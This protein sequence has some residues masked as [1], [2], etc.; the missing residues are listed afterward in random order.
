M[1]NALQ[2]QKEQIPTRKMANCRYLKLFLRRNLNL[3]SAGIY[4][5]YILF[6]PRCS[7]LQ[8]VEFLSSRETKFLYSKYIWYIRGYISAFHSHSIRLTPMIV[9]ICRKFLAQPET[10]K[11][12]YTLSL[13]KQV[14][15]FL[16]ISSSTNKIILYVFTV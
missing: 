1:R 12:N 3:P 2:L 7:A 6:V 5:I 13:P 8:A 14:L 11:E 10:F 16:F 15:S 4:I 9:L